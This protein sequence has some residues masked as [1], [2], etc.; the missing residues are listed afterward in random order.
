MPKEIFF[1]LPDE[2]REN[3]EEAIITEF[4]NYNYELAS[5]NRIIVNCGISKGSLYQYFEDKKDMYKYLMEKITNEKM[6]YM[7]PIMMNPEGYD[8]FT[9]VREMYISGLKFVEDHPRF[10]AIGNRLVK[11]TTQPIYQEII[12]DSSS[13]ANN[14]FESLLKQAFERGEIRGNIDTKFIGTLI[15]SMNTSVAEFYLENVNAKWDN[16]LMETV[17][18]FLD[19]LKFGISANN[20]GGNKND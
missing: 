5:T 8:F 6:K 10:V 14:I 19:F 2:K 12:G 18:K 7:S 20:Q 16:Q 11:D 3:I 9:I 17:D 13:I 15:S 4:E 1:N